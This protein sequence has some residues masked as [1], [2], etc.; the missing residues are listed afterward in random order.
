MRA[1]FFDIKK[2]CAVVSVFL[3]LA[4]VFCSGAPFPE[5][6][7]FLSPKMVYQEGLF[8]EVVLG[9]LE[10][11][12][13]AYKLAATL[14][15]DDHILAPLTRWRAGECY[16]MLGDAKRAF[17]IYRD[18]FRRYSRVQRVRDSAIKKF[19][20]KST[21]I[22]TNAWF[23]ST[24]DAKTM[25]QVVSFGL[26]T[27]DGIQDGVLVEESKAS[28]AVG[29][30]TFGLRV[31]DIVTEIN[32][33]KLTDAQGILEAIG[34]LKRHKGVFKVT[35]RRDNETMTIEYTV[36]DA[37]EILPGDKVE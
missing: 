13:E 9:D 16:E 36:S 26:H 33:I 19:T 15:S 2:M 31:G 7:P 21:P 14:V 29:G 22:G 37:L 1:T 20:T 3:C 27:E 17:D 30:E 4:G 8:R 28:T 35:L 10:S 11:A 25:L 24:R 6:D 34:V 12:I 23:V 18:L 32:G 5:D